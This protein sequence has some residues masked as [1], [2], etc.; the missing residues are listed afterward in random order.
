MRKQCIFISLSLALGALLLQLSS[1]YKDKGNYSYEVPAAPVVT[2]MDSVFEVFVGDSLIIEPKVEIKGVDAASLHYYWTIHVPPVAASDTDRHF[3]GKEL[4]IQYGLGARKLGARLAIENPENG[5][6]YFKDFTIIGKTAFSKG[7]TVLSNENGKSVL[8]FIKPDDELQ[9]YIFQAVNPGVEL[10]LDPTQILATPVAYQPAIKSYWIFGKGGDETGYQVDANDFTVVKTFKENFFA[11]PKGAAL[12]PE[13][14]FVAGTGV[15]SGVIDGRL[16]SGTTSTWDQAPTFGM[17]NQGAQGDYSLSKEMVFD[18]MGTYGPF[19]YIGFE[20]LKKQFVRFNL[21]GDATYFGPAYDVIKSPNGNYFDPKN[22]GMDLI[23][24]QQIIGGT[25]Y[26]YF[27]APND[28]IYEGRMEVTFN[29]PFQISNPTLKAFARQ[30]LINES[31]LW[32]AT[33]SQI[34]FF[35]DQDKVYRYNPLNDDFRVLKTDFGG[36]KVTMIKLQDQNTLV[37][38]TEGGTL[39]FLNIRTGQDGTLIKKIE[40]IP[41]AAVDIAF[42]EQ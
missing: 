26:G 42:R 18:A 15:I 31:T 23:H 39:Y 35:N 25:C 1:C 21:Y 8:T 27:R 34:I 41:G 29:G 13:H 40:G 14:I 11:V 30:D 16:Y 20:K 19:A 10:P 12:N 24:L 28:S 3:V 4:R 22:V 7:M 9:P 37:V 2:G 38:G 6:R 17:F 5:M 36:K 32:A 33:S